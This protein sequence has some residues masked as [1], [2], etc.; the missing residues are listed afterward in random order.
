MLNLSDRKILVVDDFD[1]MRNLVKGMVDPLRPDKVMTARNGSEAIELMEKTQFDLVFCDY[2]LGKG[3]DGQQILEEARHRNLLHYSAIFIMITA[4]STSEMV[5]AAIDFLPDDYISKP[6]TKSLLL[7][8]LEKIYGKKTELEEISQAI[9][10]KDYQLALELCESK[11]KDGLRGNSELLKTRADLLCR[12]GRLDDAE[13]FLEEVLEQ[14]DLP[15]A[16]LALG[17]VH[18][19][20]KLYFEAEEVFE[21]LIHENPANL[22]AHDALARTFEKMGDLRRCQNILTTAAEKSPKS[23]L[24]QRKLAEIAIRNKDF[25]VAEAAFERAIHEGK[26]S[27]YRNSSDFSGLAKAQLSQ[28]KTAEALQTI[29]GIGKEFKDSPVA[30]IHSAA[31][32]AMIHK[33][34]N[35]QKQCRE[36]LT[37]VFEIFDGAPDDLDVETAMNVIDTA[38]AVGMVGELEKIVRYVV[39]NH[40]ENELLLERIQ[41]IYDTNQ[42]T[43][44][45]QKIIKQ[46]KQ[47]IVRINNEGA[48]LLK[49]GKLEESIEFFMKAAKAM[50][51]NSTININ[52]AY[53][54]ILQ[55][56]KSGRINKY[57]PRAIKY[58]ERVL[59]YDP[60][61]KKYHQLMK[62]L[63]GL[64]EKAA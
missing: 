13:K 3:K 44:A 25:A 26:Y 11:L 41:S 56:E 24:R 60:N 6:F 51:N 34:N 63:Q 39:S 10:K 14:R 2:N 53:S 38:L 21:S 4:E 50:P 19:S 12:L 59:E 5:M 54:L 32:S 36:Y 62:R 18:F 42:V 8:R 37:E 52:V 22:I 64:T 33:E 29:K 31:T 58:L 20:K 46:T 61:N 43:E 47:N 17:E 15:W 55:I 57:Y 40:L 23:M 9:E 30:L 7:K 16:K 45:G 28:G 49:E 27:C 1:E 35:E 48:T